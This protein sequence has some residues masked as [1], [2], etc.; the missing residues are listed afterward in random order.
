MNGYN[1]QKGSEIFMLFTDW[2]NSKAQKDSTY[3]QTRIEIVKLELWSIT[4]TRDYIRGRVKLLTETANMEQKDMPKCTSEE[5]WAKETKW[6]L[7][8][9]G[10]KTAIKLCNTQPEADKL[11]KERLGMY[12]EERK[13]MAKRCKYCIARKFCT[14]YVELVKLGNCENCD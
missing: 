13:G 11:A 4:Q 7:L 10:R 9:R 14:Q 12:V 5:L 1:V 6:A 8:Q 2:S 3:P